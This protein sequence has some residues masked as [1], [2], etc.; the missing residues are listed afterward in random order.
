MARILVVDDE[1]HIRALARM[2]LVR[3]G[4]Q[5]FV[6][7]DGAAAI[8]TFREQPADLVLCDLALPGQGGLETLADLRRTCPGVRAVVMSG[9]DLSGEAARGAA[10]AL[11]RKPFR[12]EALLGAVNEAL[13]APGAG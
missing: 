4:H 2:A 1:E 9:A 8:R 5:V 12:L 3:A 11:L 13:A 6:A 7:G 10:G